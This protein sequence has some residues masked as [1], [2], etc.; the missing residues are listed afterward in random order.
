MNFLPAIPQISQQ[1]YGQGYGNWQQYAGYSKDKPFGSS[2]E[3]IPKLPTKSA[4]PPP[5]KVDT[6]FDVDYSLVNKPTPP[7]PSSPSLGSYSQMQLGMPGSSFGSNPL[8]N[9]AKADET[10]Y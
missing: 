2:Q 3:I 6:S 4:I 9:A 1:G 5:G 10:N 8:L 7:S